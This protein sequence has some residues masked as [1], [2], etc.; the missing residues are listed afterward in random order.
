MHNVVRNVLQKAKKEKS[1]RKRKVAD[2]D[3]EDP[4]PSS[5]GEQCYLEGAQPGE[6][7]G[8][9]STLNDLNYIPALQ[10]KASHLTVHCMSSSN[11]RPATRK[12][13]F[14]S[15]DRHW[16]WIAKL[17]AEACMLPRQSR[18]AGPAPCISSFGCLCAAGLSFG[19]QCLT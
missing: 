19:Q 6:I 3:K 13:G 18:C 14:H 4:L 8:R 9:C 5:T 16:Q 7:V 15:V 2:L 1:D 10:R 12:M 17:S 11:A